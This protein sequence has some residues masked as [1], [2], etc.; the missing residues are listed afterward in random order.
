[1]FDQK[2][3][4]Q[5]LATVGKQMLLFHQQLPAL[6]LLSPLTN[7]PNPI[8]TIHPASNPSMGH[9]Q[10]LQKFPWQVTGDTWLTGVTF[11]MITF[12]G[13]MVGRHLGSSEKLAPGRNLGAGPHTQ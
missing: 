9:G 10:V 4:S 6:I 7:L 11:P 1:M 2:Y 5:V 12:A 13:I 8:G 3:L